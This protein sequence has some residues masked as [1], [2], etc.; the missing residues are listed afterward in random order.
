MTCKLRLVGLALTALV[1][2]AHA[3]P[4]ESFPANTGGGAAGARGAGADPGADLDAD[5]DAE[6]GPHYLATGAWAAL[7]FTIPAWY[8][9]STQSE[10]EVDWTRPSLTDKL[11]LHALRFDTN[12]FHVNAVRHP[13]TGVGDYQIARSN[14]FG[15]LGSTIFAYAA[16]AAWELGVEYRENPAINDMIMNGAGGLGIG[17]PLYQIGQLWRGG[18]LSIADRIR[19]A[20]FSPFAATQDVWR[21]HRGWLRRRSWSDFA[22]TAGYA[23]HRLDDGS[24]RDEAAAGLDIDVVRHAGFATPGEHDGAIAAGA[25]SRFAVGGRVASLEPRVGTLTGDALVSTYLRSRTS[26]WGTYQQ[27]DAGNGRLV[28][29]G[30]AFT[31]HRDRLATDSDHVAIAHLIGPQLQLS[32]RDGTTELRWDVAAYAD[33]GMIDAYVFGG[34]ASPL[35][36][37][38][39][40]LTTLQAQGYYDGG[41]GTLETRLRIDHGPWHADLELSGHR[42]WSLDFADRDGDDSS[43]VSRVAMTAAA[44]SSSSSGSAIPATPHGVSDLRV[45]GHA[46]LGVRS[47]SWGVAATVDATYR[48]GAWQALERSTMDWTFGAVATANL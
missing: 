16:G 14:G 43:D 36:R 32:H 3:D 18:E 38:P 30:A 28:A 23:G 2:T 15:A 39:P 42:L 12:P 11:T 4:G 31:Y 9:W 26:L 40:Y 6:G 25:W 19:T 1:T 13:L 29:L 17:E 41:G 35:P 45:Y 20:A 5:P 27:D 33:F 21:A 37:P 22:V 24:V 8:Y 48:D 7:I 34:G 47:G 44:A 46:Q 10:Q